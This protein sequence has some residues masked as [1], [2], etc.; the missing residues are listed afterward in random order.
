MPILGGLSPFKKT[1]EERAETK[2]LWREKNSAKL[3]VSNKQWV[4]DNPDKSKSTRKKWNDV[5]RMV[6]KSY[7]LKH[8]Y[9][10]TPADYNKMFDIQGGCCAICKGHQSTFD[11]KLAV[12]HDHVTGEIRGLLCSPCNRGLGDFRDDVI[13]LASAIKYLNK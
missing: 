12:D 9:G 11:K 3:K 4:K 2:R 10:I 7:K 5:N 6:L 8:F 1:K 13:F